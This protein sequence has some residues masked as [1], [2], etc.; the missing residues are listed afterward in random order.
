MKTTFITIILF[1]QISLFAQCP[2]S[3]GIVS[4]ENGK[5]T[6]F[7]KLTP[8]QTKNYKNKDLKLDSTCCKRFEESLIAWQSIISK[9]EPSEGQLKDFVQ[10]YP[11]SPQWDKAKKM[12]WDVQNEEIEEAKLPIQLLQFIRENPKDPRIPEISKRI[13]KMEEKLKKNKAK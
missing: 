4:E 8:S 5:K 7:Y 1:V 6:L 3:C 12:L 2:K 13:E 10:F 11:M 9:K